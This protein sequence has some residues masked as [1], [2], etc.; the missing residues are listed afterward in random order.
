MD[1]VR[2]R[3]G[4]PEVLT[5]IFVGG[6]GGALHVATSNS[7]HRMVKSDIFIQG[8]L[9][10]GCLLGPNVGVRANKK[11]VLFYFLSSSAYLPDNL[12]ETVPYS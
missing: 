2:G 5:L 6:D 11:Y 9:I 8:L 4:R 3:K 12:L 1:H 10:L 7:I